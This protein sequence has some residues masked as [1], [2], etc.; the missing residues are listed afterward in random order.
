MSI[1]NKKHLQFIFYAWFFSLYFLIFNCSKA[2]NF[3]LNGQVREFKSNLELPFVTIIVD[4]SS[5]FL[6]DID[7]RF[8]IILQNKPKKIR[9]ASFMYR[10]VVVQEIKDS[11]SIELVRTHI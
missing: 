7:G 10:D 3:V 6:S 1:A 11:L 2:Q 8:S 9:F 5:T 4:D